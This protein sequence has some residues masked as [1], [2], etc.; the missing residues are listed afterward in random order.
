MIKVVAKKNVN[1]G[2]V[3]KVIKLY[4]ELVR[5]TRKETGCIKYELYQDEKNINILAVIEEWED[6]ECLNKH[7]NSEHFIRIVPMIRELTSEKSDMNIYNK[8][9]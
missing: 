9:I 3:E 4:E 6:K 8:L 2:E 5:E 1:E 7:M